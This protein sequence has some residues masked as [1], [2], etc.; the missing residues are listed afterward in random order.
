M[1]PRNAVE[2]L[3]EFFA[4]LND[5]GEDLLDGFNERLTEM[6]EEIL[7]RG[8]TRHQEALFRMRRDAYA[9]VRDMAFKRAT[10][11]EFLREQLKQAPKED[12]R[13]LRIQTERYAALV[14]DAQ[15]YAQH[16]H[17]LLEEGR[18]QVAEETNRS[19]RLLTIISATFLPAT[20]L[21]GMWGMN[22]DDI[23]FTSASSHG[24]WDVA[25]ADRAGAPARRRTHAPAAHPLNA[26]YGRATRRPG[27]R[28]AHAGDETCPTTARPPSSAAPS[29]EAGRSGGGC[30][31]SAWR[32]CC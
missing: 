30:S 4:A 22:V 21:T 32:R 7:E 9:L 10:L 19:V 14:E 25:G 2:L 31:R 1:K 6:Q 13:R 11:Y 26:P 15:D 3:A 8:A 17:F 28:P 27:R 29:P 16:C 18:A 24:F 23:P 12:K 5:I 20:L